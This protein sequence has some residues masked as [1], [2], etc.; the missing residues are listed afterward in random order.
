MGFPR[1]DPELEQVE[2]RIGASGETV[3]RNWSEYTFNSDFI[4]PTDGWSFKLGQSN[5]RPGDIPELIPG[6]RVQLWIGSNV[7]ATGYVDKIHRK[8]SKGSG[9][10][11]TIEGRDVMAPVV[12]AHIDPRTQFKASMTLIQMLAK[13]LHGVSAWGTENQIEEGNGANLEQITGTKK[14]LSK[15]GKLLKKAT[16]AQLKPTLGEGAFA[17][18]ARI[19]LRHGLFLWAS[20]D[21]ERLIVGEPD[22][23]IPEPAVYT[24]TRRFDGRG[25]NVIEGEHTVDLGDQPTAI[26]ADGFAGGG[27][28]GKSKSKCIMLNPFVRLLNK[29]NATLIGELKAKFKG[30]TVIKPDFTPPSEP[31]VTEMERILYLHDQDAQ[32]LDELAAFTRL[33]MSECTRKLETAKYTVKGHYCRTPQGEYAPWAVDTVVMVDD[34]VTGIN[35]PMW[36]KGRTFTKSVGAGTKTT[37]DLVALN[38]IE[39]GS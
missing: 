7:Q 23:T 2:L 38:T 20:A 34:E 39:F 13:A 22:Y 16:A 12:D 26:V 10:E 27:E 3:L 1:V 31:H 37:L 24:L 8:A 25:N 5:L 32:S 11:W 4:T 36:V 30:A 33:H 6:A 35:G 14:K 28:F 15:K 29:S 21:G 19:L 17:F 18:I 9:V